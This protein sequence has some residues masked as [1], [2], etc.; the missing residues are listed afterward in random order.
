MP[1]MHYKK[2]ILHTS[3]IHIEINPSIKES[4]LT[5]FGLKIT[6]I[7][8]NKAFDLVDELDNAL[9]KKYISKRFEL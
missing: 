7:S 2:H 6:S 9:L 8:M 5:K 1:N 4:M 3:L